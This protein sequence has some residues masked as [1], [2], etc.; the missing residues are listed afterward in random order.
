MSQQI[1]VAQKT[2]AIENNFTF[3]GEEAANEAGH[4]ANL[5]NQLRLV[6]YNIRVEV[7]GFQN[8]HGLREARRCPHCNLIWTK[9][10]GCNGD[11]T[12]GNLPSAGI[13]VRSNDF[14]VLG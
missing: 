1:I 14:G 5:T 12:C 13:D 10:E 8:D 6:L 9:I 11:T 3:F 4:I 7:A 2:L